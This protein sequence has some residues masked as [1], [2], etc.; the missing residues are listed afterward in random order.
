MNDVPRHHTARPEG[1]EPPVAWVAR[2][3]RAA[4][5]PSRERVFWMRSLAAVSALLVLTICLTLVL[6]WAKAS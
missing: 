2:E 3:V 6:E 5:G 1:L 4:E